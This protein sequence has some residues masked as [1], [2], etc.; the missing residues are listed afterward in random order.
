MTTFDQVCQH[1]TNQYQ[2]YGRPAA[3]DAASAA[4][5]GIVPGGVYKTDNYEHFYCEK[6]SD[7]Y[8]KLIVIAKL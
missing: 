3:L 8:Y 6:I 5:A 7:N 4:L 1:V 2:T